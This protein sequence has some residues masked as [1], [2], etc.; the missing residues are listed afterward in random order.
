MTTGER[1][2]TV[3]INAVMHITSLSRAQVYALERTGE[4]P[5]RIMTTA[6]RG[7]WTTAS[8]R[9]WMQAK[10]GARHMAA[11]DER[12][13]PGDRFITKKELTLLVPGGH[14]AT[15]RLEQSGLFPARFR[16]SRTRL[17]WLERDVKQ[18][19][20]RRRNTLLAGGATTA[21]DLHPPEAISSCT[22]TFGP[23]PPR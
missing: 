23:A 5:A 8:V 12:I 22:P 14:A 3:T 9:Q 11:H 13:L 2:T 18:W 17:A 4:F 16:I 1:L 6:T 15:L 20:A 10:L 7:A 19:V 21:T